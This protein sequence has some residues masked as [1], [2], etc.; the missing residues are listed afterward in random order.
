MKSF[1]S[2]ALL[3]VATHHY[4]GVECFQP[5][6]V[7]MKN[8]MRLRAP[9]IHQQQQKVMQHHNKQNTV[10][11]AARSNNDMSI[12]ELKSELAAYLKKRDEA[13][14]NEAAKRYV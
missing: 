10:L 9:P 11:S 14:A 1:N 6:T 5:N 12:D 3:V 4:V 8:N 7:S 13:N 2:L